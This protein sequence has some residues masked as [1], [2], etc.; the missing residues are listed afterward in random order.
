MKRFLLLV[1][2]FTVCISLCSCGNKARPIYQQFVSLV[3]SEKYQDAIDYFMA[4][5]D[6]SSAGSYAEFKEDLLAY[7]D[8]NDYFCYALAL[9]RYVGPE[10]RSLT[11]IGDLKNVSP[12][13]LDSDRYISEIQTQQDLLNGIY[14]CSEPDNPVKHYIIIKDGHIWFA[15]G[16]SVNELGTADIVH[17]DGDPIALTIN[18]LSVD[19][20]CE[21]ES[22]WDLYLNN[23]KYVAGSSL[24][25]NNDDIIFTLQILEK[26]GASTLA[27]AAGK[28]YDMFTGTYEKIQS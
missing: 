13:F 17:Y 8:F 7:K 28:R 3:E 24:L 19:E 12:G 18:N 16:L 11:C 6:K 1:T 25:E 14:E 9:E 4:E 26:D 27:G 15:N 20:F 10:Y 5:Y 2:T 23:D 21:L 22:S